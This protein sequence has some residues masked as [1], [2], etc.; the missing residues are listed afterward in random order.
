MKRASL[1]EGAQGEQQR[2]PG[3]GIGWDGPGLGSG[4]LLKA[5]AN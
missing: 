1:G 4:H 5:L 2:S 3:I